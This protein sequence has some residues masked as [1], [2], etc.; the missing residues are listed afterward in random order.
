MKKTLVVLAAGMGSRYGGLKQIDPVGPGGETLMD[1]SIYDALRAGFEKLVFVIRRDIERP[2][3]E[4]IGRRFEDRLAVDYVFQEIDRLPSGYAVPAGRKKPWGTA[5]AILVARQAVNEP[6]GVINADDFYGANS[7]RALAGHL[8]SNSGDYA[9][10]GFRLRNTLS[11]F[12]SVARGVCKVGRG[13]FLESIVELT[14][15]ERDGSGARY[16][17]SAGAVHGLTGDEMVSLNIWG[18]T[19]AIFEQLESEF[20]DF[21]NEHRQEEKAEFFIS[22]V[23]GTLVSEGKS[24]VKV[25]STPDSWFGITY[26]EDRAVVVEGIKRLVLRGDYPGRLW[27][28]E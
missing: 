6:F 19:P 14:R 10:V 24:R 1:Y 17:D 23:V 4:T 8:D 18:F 5:H 7:F 3:K 21:L 2:F 12:G 27:T 9:M 28:R 26:K 15:I 11:E 20:V 13:D 22:S 16:T 25:L